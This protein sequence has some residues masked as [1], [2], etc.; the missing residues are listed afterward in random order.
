MEI[1]GRVLTESAVIASELERKFPSNN[2][3]MPAKGTDLHQAAEGLMRCVRNSKSLYYAPYKSIFTP[4]PY[5][6]R[7]I[8]KA[9]YA[10]YR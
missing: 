8:F 5:I 4:K 7:T 3:L 6:L 10:P 9:P 1:D 2:P